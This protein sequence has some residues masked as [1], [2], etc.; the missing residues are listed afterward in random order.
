LLGDV[1]PLLRR[2]AGRSSRPPALAAQPAKLDRM[3]V[4]RIFN[5]IRHLAGRYIADQLSQGDGVARSLKASL[6][7]VLN[8]RG[9]VAFVTRVKGDAFSN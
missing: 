2:K 7:H 6:D 5:T 4:S 1:A 3:R 9:N 8:M